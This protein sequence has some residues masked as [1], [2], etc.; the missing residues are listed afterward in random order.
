M[1]PRERAQSSLSQEL[2][3]DWRKV[4][5]LTPAPACER[6]GG[7]TEPSLA[8]FPPITGRPAGSETHWAPGEAELARQ[9]AGI[10]E[11]KNQ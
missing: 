8:S 5:K 2:S 7:E 4:P 11:K 10:A 9:E 1:E 3:T 6:A